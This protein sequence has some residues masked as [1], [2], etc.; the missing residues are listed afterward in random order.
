[1]IDQSVPLQTL[2][3]EVCSLRAQ[4]RLLQDKDDIAQVIR[5]V[6]RATD[7]L[8]R[9][10]FAAQFHPDAQIDYGSIYQGSVG[11]FVDLAMQFQGAM[12][13]T[14]HLI[15]NI[16]IQI[17]GDQAYAESYVY[18]HHVLQKGA[19]LEELIVGGR[20]L[21]RLARRE[22]AWRIAFRTEVIDWGRY[23]PVTERWYEDN[24]ELAKGRRGHQD[25]SYQLLRL[26]R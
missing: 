3:E 20:Y 24:S 8:D 5:N 14:Q 17:D 6:A 9:E 7:R 1:M 23:V 11:G 25:P 4:V 16:S 21:D 10:L 19:D 12:R 18:A 22:G 15:G 2:W 26:S 13:D